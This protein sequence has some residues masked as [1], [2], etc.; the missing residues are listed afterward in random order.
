MH[1]DEFIDPKN[2]LTVKIKANCCIGFSKVISCGDLVF[3]S[4]FN[5]NILE[6]KLAINCVFIF[7]LCYHL[8][9]QN[10][11]EHYYTFSH[12]K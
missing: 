2:A 11:H 10:I 9:N 7:F 5:R 1:I 3:S 12:K 8:R 4:I 6:K